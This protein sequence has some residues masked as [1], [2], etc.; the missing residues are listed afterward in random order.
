MVSMVMMMKDDDDGHQHE[1]GDDGSGVVHDDNIG[2]YYHQH[3]GVDDNYDHDT[4]SQV[5]GLCFRTG[6]GIITLGKSS[7]R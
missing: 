6:G 2:D 7:N 5:F 1:G 4:I 3:C